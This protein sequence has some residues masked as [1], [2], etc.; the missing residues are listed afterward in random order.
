MLTITRGRTFENQADIFAPSLT[1]HI[2]SLEAGI[3]WFFKAQFRKH[4]I[5]LAIHYFN[6]NIGIN[7]IYN[8]NLLSTMRLC[9]LAWNAIT[10]A[11]INNFLD[12]TQI[13]PKLPTILK[14]FGSTNA[15]ASLGQETDHLQEMDLIAPLSKKSISNVE[16]HQK[17]AT[18]K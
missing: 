6:S 17:K 13:I 12:H 4:F 14:N 1:S 7:K 16:M 11:K 3:I 10:P 8:I 5:L 9:Q 18:I 2:K 15:E